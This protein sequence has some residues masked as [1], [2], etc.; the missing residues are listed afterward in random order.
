MSSG[1]GDSLSIERFVC[2]DLRGEGKKPCVVGSS[3][4]TLEAFSLDCK[5]D[6]VT[7]VLESFVVA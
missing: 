7:E 6:I 1:Y 3:K 4:T 5:E 2:I